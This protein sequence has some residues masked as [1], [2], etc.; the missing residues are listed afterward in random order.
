M[1][2]L[3]I[4]SAVNT[5]SPTSASASGTGKTGSS[6]GFAGALVQAIGGTAST[7]TASAGNG[8]TA[9]LAGLLGLFSAPSEDS[10]SAGLLELLAGLTKALDAQ[11]PNAKLPDELQDQLAALLVM[12]QNLLNP[13]ASEMPDNPQDALAVL[14]SSIDGTDA[15]Q[16]Q[17]NAQLGWIAALKQTAQNLT[18]RLAADSTLD[19]QA[20]QV[21]E[22]LQQAVNALQQLQGDKTASKTAGVVEARTSAVDTASGAASTANAAADQQSGNAPAEV[23]AEVRKAAVPFRNPAWQY[24]TA[25]SK[26]TNPQTEGQIPATAV[27]NTDASSQNSVPVWTLLKSADNLTAAASTAN[28]S[29][30]AQVPVQQFAEQM[31]KFLVKQFVLTQGHGTAE[32]KISLH[33]EHLGQVD[34]KIMIQNGLLTA[35]FTAENGAA[36]DLLENQMAQLR[37]ALQGQ[38][39]QVDRMEVVQQSAGA[40]SAAFFQQFQGRSGSNSQG[41]QSRDRGAKGVYEDP[42]AFEAE[43]DRTSFLREI[44]YGS[45]LNVT[46]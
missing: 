14:T 6:G 43:L 37:S 19:A 2:A 36:R 7:G 35:Q 25:S 20:P 46:A 42:A 41:G 4:V 9:G 28:A 32:A 11:D 18:D 34:I 38:G 22:S 23:Q 29:V 8:I 15:L 12:L 24:A 10:S 31:G 45:S 17:S 33:P 27:E 21:K 40:E 1:N 26:E 13:S 44:G 16:S 30:P 3:G 5:A 39:L